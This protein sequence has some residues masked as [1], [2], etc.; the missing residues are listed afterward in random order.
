MTR[1]GGGLDGE[2]FVC[3]VQV[4]NGLRDNCTDSAFLRDHLTMVRDDENPSRKYSP[5][6]GK[7]IKVT[8]QDVNMRIPTQVWSI[9]EAGNPNFTLT[10]ISVQDNLGIC[11]M[12]IPLTSMTVSAKMETNRPV[13]NVAVSALLNN[14]NTAAALGNTD[15]NGLTTLQNLPLGQNF[16]I[17][18]DKTDEPY[19]GVTTFDVA[20]M[21]RHILDIE[22]ITSPY[23]LLAGDVNEDG[24]IDATDILLIRNFILQRIPALPRRSW[25]FVDSSYVFRNPRNPFAEDVPEIIF[26]PNLSENTRK[27]FKAIKKGD[28]STVSSATPTASIF[29]TRNNT[30]L[31]IQTEDRWIEK[32]K[33]YA[34]AFN[35]ND[36]NALSYQFTLGFT[37]GGAQVQSIEAANDLTYMNEGNFGIFKEA[38]TTSWNGIAT[39]KTPQLFTLHF[40]ANQSGQL[41]E[42]LSINS[43]K[44]LS[45]AYNSA[46]HSMPIELKFNNTK[47]PIEQLTLYQNH[48]N[49]FDKETTIAFNLP[50]ETKA[51][52]TIYNTQGQIIY[53]FSDAYKA[54]YNE[55]LV[56]KDVLKASGVLYYRLDT[57]EHSATR[58]MIVFK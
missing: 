25:R 9:D 56:S 47:A 44:T 6:F 53:T 34:I 58:K 40:V 8:C 16:Q 32:G 41:S 10:Y 37:E 18:A 48:P 12:A 38:I 27:A 3:A 46:G 22:R 17:K 54:G 43:S 36:F 39:T 52:L 30:K 35:S 28:V 50:K 7:C 21:S 1:S 19:L 13:K 26:I 2:T 5:T 49:P 15:V 45:E 31:S 11:N 29:E 24:E 14:T 23:A 51:K 57:P 20:I 42:M 4:L 55:I 33:E